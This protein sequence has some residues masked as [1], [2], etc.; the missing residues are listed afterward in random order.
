MDKFK[1]LPNSKSLKMTTLNMGKNGTE[2][3]KKGGKDCR[4]RRNCFL[5]EIFLFSTMF[6]KGFY[7]RHIKTRDNLGKG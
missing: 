2:F 7:C 4:K 6:L 5:Q 3:S 1:T